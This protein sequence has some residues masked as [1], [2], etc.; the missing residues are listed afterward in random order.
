MEI[1]AQFN[2]FFSCS[3]QMLLFLPILAFCHTN[4]TFYFSP[5]SSPR[6]NSQKQNHKLFISNKLSVPTKLITIKSLKTFEL[7]FSDGRQ[8]VPLINISHPLA[9]S[10]HFPK[11]PSVIVMDKSEAKGAVSHLYTHT[12][13]IKKSD[14]SWSTSK[15]QKHVRKFPFSL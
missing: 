15:E 14:E 3:A 12:S 13:S 2:S 4:Y 9:F 6:L 11:Y 10:L 1:W 5:K 8:G 7:T